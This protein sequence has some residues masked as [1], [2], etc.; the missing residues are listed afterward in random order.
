MPFQWG[1]FMKLL[2]SVSSLNKYIIFILSLFFSVNTAWSGHD[3]QLLATPTFSDPGILSDVPKGWKS[4]PLTYEKNHADADLV[5]ALGQQSYPLFHDLI[6]E[7]ANKNQLKIVVRHG[8]CGITSGRLRKKSVDIGAFCCPPAKSDRLPG[9]EF[10]S[11]GVSPIALIV[12]P[13]NPLTNVSTTQ[14]RE[15]LQGLTR[16][17]TQLNSPET[18]NFNQLIKPIARLHCKTRPGHWRGLLNNEDQFSPRLFEVGV[19]SDMLSQVS[20]S[21]GA[22]GW[23]VPL[24]VSYYRKK[25]QVRMLKIDGHEATDMKYL[26]SGKYPLYRSYSLATWTENTGQKKSKKNIEAM[27]LIM[28]LQQY[29]EKTH[30]GISYIPPSQLRNAGWKFQGDELI[31]EP[32]VERFSSK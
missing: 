12:H 28:F 22:I 30:N 11:L 21:T 23:E 29:V 9:L 13:D 26:L 27:K 15:I 5:V 2:C 10:H 6:L 7:Y 31:G 17:W 25:G 3:E 8:T 18:N 16:H 19:I 32:G 14:A 20:R 1:R 24:M 4:K